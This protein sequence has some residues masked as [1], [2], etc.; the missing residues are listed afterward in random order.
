MMSTNFLTIVGESG[1]F[2]AIVGEGRIFEIIKDEIMITP[3]I[4]IIAQILELGVKLC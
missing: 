1:V 3:T 2:S 4:N